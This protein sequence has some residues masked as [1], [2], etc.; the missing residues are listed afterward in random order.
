MKVLVTGDPGG[1]LPTLLKRVAAVIAAVNEPNRPF[2]LLFC[3]GSF[4]CHAGKELASGL[5]SSF[6]YTIVARI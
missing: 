2:P 1:C 5:E 4:C 6:C 3:V